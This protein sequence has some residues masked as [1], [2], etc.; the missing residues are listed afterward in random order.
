MGHMPPFVLAFLL[1]MMFILVF[2]MIIA[3]ET[4]PSPSYGNAEL[5]TSTYSSF[6]HQFSIS[7]YPSVQIWNNH[8]LP[9]RRDDAAMNDI[10]NSDISRDS[11]YAVARLTAY[12]AKVAI[13]SRYKIH[14]PTVSAGICG[15]GFKIWKWTPTY[16][17]TTGL[18]YDSEVSEHIGKS[19]KPNTRASGNTIYVRILAFLSSSNECIAYD[20]DDSL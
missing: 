6:R 1:I 2:L 10:E 5:W 19:Q 14:R 4:S 20:I 17:T 13:S 16:S 11:C 18:A 15:T 8:P 9:Q 12:E 3:L 7:N